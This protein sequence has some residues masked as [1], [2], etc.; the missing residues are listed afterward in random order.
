MAEPAVSVFRRLAIAATTARRAL[1]DPAFAAHLADPPPEPAAPA[2]PGLAPPAPP[3]LREATPDA[4]LQLLGLLQQEGRFLDF[5]EEEIRAYGDAE[6][7]AAA[8]LVHDGCRKTLRQHFTIEPIRAEPEGTRLTLAEGFDAAA[9]RLTGHL[10]G[11]PPFTGQLA[12]RGW[13]A[14]EVRLPQVAAGHDL[15]ILAQAEVEL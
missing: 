2:P 12:H 15:A 7:G 3:R 1:R 9:V 8:R 4:A 5:L 13:R 14:T 10:V 6:I 11:Q